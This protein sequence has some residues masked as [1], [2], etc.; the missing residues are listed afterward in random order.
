MS[1]TVSSSTT[2]P[3]LDREYRPIFQ[4][5]LPLFFQR[6]RS[7]EIGS[8]RKYSE[9]T[10]LC[11][12]AL[13]RWLIRVFWGMMFFLIG[14]GIFFAC[15]GNGFET[16]IGF[17]LA[18]LAAVFASIAKSNQFL[19][20]RWIVLRDGLLLRSSKDRRVFFLWRSIRGFRTKYGFQWSRIAVRTEINGDE[21]VE[22]IHAENDPLLPFLTKLLELLPE[23]L[24]REPLRRL[25]RKLRF[26]LLHRRLFSTKETN[27]VWATMLCIPVIVVLTLF[28][29]V[30]KV[31]FAIWFAMIGAV[32]AVTFGAYMFVRIR[33]RR[34]HENILNGLLDELAPDAAIDVRSIM[35]PEFGPPPRTVSAKAKRAI[36][37]AGELWGIFTLFCCMFAFAVMTFAGILFWI[38]TTDIRY[39]FLPLRWEKAGNGRIFGIADSSTGNAPNGYPAP[40]GRDLLTLE[41]T[42]PDGRTIRCRNPTSL[43]PGRFQV[44]Q[45]V[46]LL[47]YRSDPESLSLDDPSSYGDMWAGFVLSCVY[48]MLGPGMI[49]GMICYAFSRRRHVVRLI[50]TAPL[51]RFRAERVKHRTMLVP[52]AS[53]REPIP[54]AG[55]TVQ[56]GEMVRVFLDERKPEASFVAE[57]AW[58]PL[59]VDPATGE[60]DA[61][62]DRSCWITFASLGLLVLGIALIL[63]RVLLVY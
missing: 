60:I 35:P 29:P 40:S 59:T 56:P 30:A 21:Q 55:L 6:R 50:E 62:S 45:A 8:P 19:P 51:E 33:M 31:G 4:Q 3:R 28:F 15:S 49:G 53:G 57:S 11:R 38:G 63:L 1:N 34:R 17:E 22:W 13:Y 23:E 5:L 20:S 54:A 9:S 44:G 26:V 36:L 7:V 42:L 27:V 48:L 52:L 2:D 16:V 47:R 58:P 25:Q 14:L 24:D 61:V 18:A 10:R 39:H 46:P 37:F 12:L 41:Q 43:P 32:L